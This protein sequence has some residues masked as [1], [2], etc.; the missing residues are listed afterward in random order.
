[1]KRFF[2]LTMTFTLILTWGLAGSAKA[3]DEEHIK[4]MQV[5]LARNSK[6]QRA[7]AFYLYAIGKE[8]EDMARWEE[9]NRAVHDIVVALGGSISAEHG[10]GQ[11]KG[12][13]LQLQKSSI[14]IELMQRIKAA[15]DP[16]LIM[17]PGKVL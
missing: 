14:E 16:Q 15:I 5:L 3:Q 4:Q 10:L 11:I 1:M 9:V 6:N 2:I 8:Y 17:N 12:Q 13:Y 7:R